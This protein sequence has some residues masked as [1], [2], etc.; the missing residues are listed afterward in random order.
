MQVLC[1]PAGAEGRPARER[2]RRRGDRELRL[3][4]P[5]ARDLGE[6]LCV[7]RREVG[8]APV[9]RDALAADEVVRRDLDSGDRRA[10]HADA[11]ANATVAT[12]TGVWPPS[13]GSTAP[14]T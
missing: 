4:L 9:A 14:L 1:A 7:D 12:S 2:L 8:E 6:R 10:A 5:A 13:I 11:F 3:P